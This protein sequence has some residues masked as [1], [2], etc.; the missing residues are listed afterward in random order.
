MVFAQHQALRQEDRKKFNARICSTDY[1]ELLNNPEINTVIIGTR[2]NTHTEI[3]LKALQ[4][5]KNIF[6]EKPLCLNMDELNKIKSYI[7]K[8]EKCLRFSLVLTE[9]FS[10]HA[11]K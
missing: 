11:Q 10:E 7:E 4:A 1:N 5:N 6:I 8:Q 9:G 2:H 3:L